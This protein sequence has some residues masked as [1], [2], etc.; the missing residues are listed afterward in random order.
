MNNYII[1]N[2]KQLEEMIGKIV[3]DTLTRV[4][5]RVLPSCQNTTNNVKKEKEFLNI[6]ETQKLLG[7]YRNGVVKLMKNGELPY[8]KSKDG[9]GYKIRRTDILNLIQIKNADRIKL[10]PHKKAA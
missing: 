1:Q 5:L 4:L 9:G 6:S 7:M 3:E 2:E 10:Y 8:F